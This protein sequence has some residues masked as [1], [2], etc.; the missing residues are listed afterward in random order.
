MTRTSLITIALV[1]T[2]FAV[3]E[4]AL[5]RGFK[6]PAIPLLTVDPQFSVW[7]PSVNLTESFSMQWT[8][9]IKALVGMIRIDGQAYRFMGPENQAGGT[10]PPA[11]AQT[12]VQVYP[13]RT[14]FQ[15]ANDK[16]RL[17]VIF[18]TPLLADDYDLLSRPITYITVRVQP[19]G[20]RNIQIYLDST[21]EIAVNQVSEMINWEKKKITEKDV[22]MNF[23]RVG[24]TEQKIMGVVC[25]R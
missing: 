22:T 6:P 5:T 19:L 9:A 14:I 25:S 12:D 16:A 7:S 17:Q 11:I 15:F 20:K 1:C 3:G 4:G 23:A 10:I 21:G 18:S 13:T 2:L 8:G 24:T